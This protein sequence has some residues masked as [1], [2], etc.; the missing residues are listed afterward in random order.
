[1]STRQSVTSWVSIP[2]F[3]PMREPT[4]PLVVAGGAVLVLGLAGAVGCAIA[5]TLTAPYS[6]R[7][8]STRILGVSRNGDQSTV[9]LDN[10]AQT[11]QQGRYGAF[12]PDGRHIRFS[13]AVVTS[14]TGVAREVS[15]SAADALAGV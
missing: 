11:R 15:A 2:Q 3:V 4:V 14:D 10:T 9:A 8:Y 13:F 5:R 6:G 1:L 7:R 12:L